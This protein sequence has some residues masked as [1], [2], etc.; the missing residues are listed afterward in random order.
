MTK[1]SRKPTPDLK[2][3]SGEALTQQRRVK[4]DARSV[5]FLRCRALALQPF[6]L[7]CRLPTVP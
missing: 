2:E 3:A 7:S 1:A 6:S 5:A 4:G